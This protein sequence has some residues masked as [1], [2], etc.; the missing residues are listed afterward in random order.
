MGNSNRKHLLRTVSTSKQEIETAGGRNGKEQTDTAR[1]G[2]TAAGSVGIPFEGG[3]SS[4]IMPGRVSRRPAAL[5]LAESAWDRPGD[6]SARCCAIGVTAMAHFMPANGRLTSP[7]CRNAG[8]S[9][10]KR[11]ANC[12]PAAFRREGTI[13]IRLHVD[14]GAPESAGLRC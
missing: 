2:K 5:S 11:N 6:F 3:S 13:Q 9:R 4:R 12:S 7:A 14:L 10:D 8:C 1:G